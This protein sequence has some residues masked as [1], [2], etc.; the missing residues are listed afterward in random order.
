MR[1]GFGPA[2]PQ[3]RTNRHNMLIPKPAERSEFM[4]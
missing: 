2:S 1:R 3:G 4:P